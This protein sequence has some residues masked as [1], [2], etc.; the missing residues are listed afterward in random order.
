VLL[1]LAIWRGLYL[2]IGV[3]IFYAARHLHGIWLTML[4]EGCLFASAALATVIMA[5]I[6]QSPPGIYGLPLRRAFGRNFWIGSVWGMA[7][8]SFLLL[9]MRGAGVFDLG[10]FSLHGVRILKFAAFWGLMFLLVAF[11]EELL[12]R[13][14]ILFTLSQSIGFWPSALLFSAGFGLL[15]VSNPGETPLGIAAVATIGLFFCLTV[16]RTGTL[17]FA[18]GFHAAWDWGETYFYS[19][20]DSGQVLPGHLLN[21]SFHGPAWLSGGSVGPEGSALLFVAVAIT[22]IVFDRVYPAAKYPAIAKEADVI[23]RPA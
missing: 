10:S 14:Y 9:V 19:V 22:W 12:A 6:E 11:Y 21:P 15:H 16:R 8:L 13:G 17:W 5:A 20:P 1:F 18:V 3:S 23:V 2:F 4:V 7:S